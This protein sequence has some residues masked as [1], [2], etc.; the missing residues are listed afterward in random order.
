MESADYVQGSSQMG[1][2]P[3][4]MHLSAQRLGGSLSAT[5]YPPNDS[6]GQQ[7]LHRRQ[8]VLPV[9]IHKVPSQ[10][11]KKRK[12]LSRRFGLQWLREFPWLRYDTEQG[13]MYCAY[14]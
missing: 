12:Y 9:A 10:R 13:A 4:A 1:P 7:Y 3:I 2:I 14:C 5:A 8:Q 11:M 6:N